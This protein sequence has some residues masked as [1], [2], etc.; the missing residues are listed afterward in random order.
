MKR[1]SL[2]KVMAKLAEQPEKV[3]LSM[4]ADFMDEFRYH[5]GKF[6]KAEGSVKEAI[7]T[8]SEVKKTLSNLQED[9]KA[10]RSY[11]NRVESQAKELGLELDSSVVK[12]ADE[13]DTLIK[14][15]EKMLS[16]LK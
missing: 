7:S 8:V 6:E 13:V 14:Q 15:T 9:F 5:K 3:E 10:T 4:V 1:I 2:N 16:D 11:Y 12:A